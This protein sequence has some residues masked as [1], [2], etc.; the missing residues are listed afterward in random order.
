MNKS[1]DK[2]NVILKKIEFWLVTWFQ[3]LEETDLPGGLCKDCANNAL[4]AWNFRLLCTSSDEEWTR[5]ATVLARNTQDLTVDPQ[6]TVL[7]VCLNTEGVFKDHVTRIHNLTEAA[8]TLNNVVQKKERQQRRE[9]SKK[10]IESI[11]IKSKCRYCRKVFNLPSHLNQH[12]SSMPQGACV[13]CGKVLA[14]EKL[15]KHLASLH[16]KTVYN[17]EV[18]HQIF[19]DQPSLDN[20]NRLHS[21]DLPQCK[22]CKQGFK[23]DRSLRAHMYA[24]TL[25]TC[26]NCCKS[27]ENRKCFMYHKEHCSGTK[28]CIEIE[29][30]YEC[31]DCGMKYTKKPS[32]RIHIIQKHL[33][34]LPYVCQ[35]CGKRSSTKNHH[36]SHELVHTKEREIYQC[37]CGAKMKSSVGYKMHQRI[38]SGEK[39]YECKHCGDRFLSASR[40]L[41]HIKRRHRT[42]PG[43]LA[44]VCEKCGAAFVRPFELKRHCRA[45]HNELLP[46]TRTTLR[47]NKSGS[48]RYTFSLLFSD[49]L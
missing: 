13:V 3:V 10:Q 1:V 21:L 32:L 28:K 37:F 6:D 4:L 12:L 23:S 33:N 45:A 39:P 26:S 16:G 40:R 7:Y 43:A 15:P 18:C 42:A 27:F 31:A 41:D 17:C 46:K 35:I 25:F 24:H 8:Q 48:C 49:Y 36:K 22:I 38:H 19:E 30:T 14:R 20:H 2:K 11:H 5:V 29:G 44:H 47:I 9:Q 34:V